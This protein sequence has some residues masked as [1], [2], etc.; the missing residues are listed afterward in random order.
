MWVLPLLLLELQENNI[1]LRIE[2]ETFLKDRDEAE[3][4]SPGA[5]KIIGK[6]VVF[7]TM[8]FPGPL[9]V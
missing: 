9:Q 2:D 3:I 7:E 4:E 5:R 8:D 6:S 1:L